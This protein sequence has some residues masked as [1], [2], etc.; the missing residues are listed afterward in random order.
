MVVAAAP[1]WRRVAAG[2]LP[3]DVSGERLFNGRVLLE[4]AVQEIKA[5]TSLDAAELGVA[6]AA[7]ADLLQVLA[8]G[9]RRPARPARH[10]PARRG[11]RPVRRPDRAGDPA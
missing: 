10:R 4:H 1:R 6:V 9:L 8:I 11:R 2:W 5:E 7:A 3:V